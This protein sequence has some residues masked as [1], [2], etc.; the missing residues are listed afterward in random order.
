MNAEKVR[1]LF[2]E[3]VANVPPECWDERLAQFA[4]AD[5]DL[6]RRVRLLLAAH[7][8]DSF[9]DS[10]APALGA[11][12]DDP[13]TERPG[14]VVGPY[15]LLEQ[16]G[17]GGFGVVFLAEQNR[18]V[19]R[20][21]ALK[22]LKPG[23]D[24][25]QV[26]ARF[27]A[28][29]Q[30]LALMD[31]P[32]IAHILDGGETASGRPYF[33]MELVRGVPITDF[34][35]QNQLPVRKRLELF[36]ACC[37]AVQHAHQKGV[38]HRDIKPSNVLVTR[39]DDQAVVKVIDF[40]IA[41]ATG[42]RLTEKTL[43]SHYAQMIGTPLYM[44]PEQAQLNGL[45]VDT[46]SDVYALG[47]LLYE[48]LT[49]MTPF[50]QERLR[51]VGY[52]EIRRIIREEEPARPSMRLS[53]LAQAV[54]TA[55]ANRR[56][57]PKRLSQLFRGELDWI[58]MKALEKDRGRRYETA[59]AF[60]A[61]V[62]RYLNDEAVLACPPSVGY[63][64]CKFA[65]RN[66]GKL[67]AAGLV[68]FFLMLLVVGFG[69][70]ARD[71]AAR[72]E[73][74]QR[75]VA[76]A[77]DEAQAFYRVDH[78]PEALAVVQRAEALLAGGGDNGELSPAVHRVLTDVRLAARLEEIRLERAAVKD[79]SFDL[80][81]VD[82][83]YGDAFRRYGLDLAAL[84]DDQAAERIRA[85]AIKDRLVA[86]L[87]GWLSAKAPGGLPGGER[88]LA[89]LRRADTDAWRNRFRAAF[90]RRDKRALKD[91][92]RDPKALVQPPPTVGLLAQGLT[93][94]GEGPL[95]AKVLRRAQQQ[96]PADLWLNHD[97]ATCLMQLKPVQAGEAVAYYR[98][99]RAL[100]PDSPG[101]VMNLGAALEAKGDL[102]E[103]IIAFQKAITL[104]PS[105]AEAHYNLGNALDAKGNLPGAIA[106]YRKAIAL[107]P[108]FAEAHCNLGMALYSKGDLSGAGAALRRA[109]A[110]KPDL[111][112]AHNGRGLT[113][114]AKGDLPGAIAAYRQAAALKPSLAKAHCNLGF[115]LYKKGDL[116]GGAAAL[117]K[118]IALQPDL[119]RAYT[120]LGNA[121]EANSDLPGAIAAYRKAIALKP[122]FAEA[123]CH[124]GY[125]LYNKDDLPGALATLRKAIALKPDFA[126]AYN[127]LGLTLDARGD[128]PGALAAYRKAI[129]LRPDLDLAYTNLGTALHQQRDLSG[130]IAA[131]Q[132]ALAIR[133]AFAE[134]HC[135]LG[136]TLNASGDLLG[137]I[138]AYR[139]A[140]RLKP[141]L[142]MAHYNLGAA[143]CDK[144][145]WLGAVAAYRK[146]VAL[147]PA[148]AAAH[149]N[150]GQV[151]RK[152][153]EFRKALVALRRG[154]ELGSKRPSWPYPSARWVRECECLAELDGRLP[155]YLT[156]KIAPA[157]A[158][159]R[160]KLAEVCYVKHLHRAAARF[161][162]EGFAAKPSLLAAQR[163]N[164]AGAA[165]LAGCGQGQDAALLDERE[166]ARLRSLALRWL[167]DEL[168]FRRLQ[169]QLARWAAQEGNNRA[170]LEPTLRHWQRN[171]DL[172]GV[173]DPDRL[174][175]LPRGE[176]QGWRRLWA[177]VAKTLNAVAKQVSM[178]DV[179]FPLTKEMVS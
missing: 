69:W 130:A 110:V 1:E 40:G 162:E 26:V 76:R 41:K 142:P 48:L 33:V 88:L 22:I 44:S 83:S 49:G 13:I 92:A 166:R 45:D 173:R 98:V 7:Q 151:L 30:A 27:E 103:A 96:H 171:P 117:R 145:D 121:R 47:V 124:L 102:S 150:L 176:Q 101:V 52:D 32:N 2:V 94:V 79:G 84:D 59:S 57:D 160:I 51:T 167:R 61:D 144:G 8:D 177:E 106:A 87:D 105:Y 21:V 134:A 159:E 58:V 55:S 95:A 62:E 18:P 9:L 136:L 125:A 15:K 46:R 38:I 139:K 28:E 128:L 29:R 119:A 137:A 70:V 36:V 90:Q 152:Q 133:P 118:A 108:S 39:H 169:G 123:Y 11:M 163:S 112:I 42:Q 147:N 71:R 53:T 66:K 25:R 178:A 72:Q 97:L 6:C 68:L 43:V 67:T 135:N 54:T 132:K 168:A 77:M 165:A 4:G 114:E 73:A 107:K 109:L 80:A 170:T 131:H 156:G 3:L 86:G 148:Y 155:S 60:A 14:T 81:G 161:Y 19:R 127:I 78:L 175:R 50:D 141:N 153:G 89:V 17:E 138:A 91:L 113:R 64:F 56:S 172:A 120:K 16:I 75:K 85:S 24:T 143:L 126:T 82:R 31:H 23:M 37:Q 5:E 116:S 63:R 34:C 158:D 174:A 146:A 154:H 111:A 179:P 74:L 20:T 99:A 149:C 93:R 65:R 12:L 104:K 122:D 35:D 157:S 129:A 140:I 164:A 100:R 115:A 10:P